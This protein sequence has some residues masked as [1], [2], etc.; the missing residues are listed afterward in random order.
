M[1]RIPADPDFGR[2]FWQMEGRPT[3][4]EVSHVQRFPINRAVMKYAVVVDC[5]IHLFT[6]APYLFCCECRIGTVDLPM[7][8][9]DKNSF[10]AGE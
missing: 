4:D 2:V 1:P 3:G 9:T 8:R 5:S 7:Y 10:R 6:D